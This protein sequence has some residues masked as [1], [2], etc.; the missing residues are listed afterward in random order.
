M[1][2]LDVRVK[3]LFTTREGYWYWFKVLNSNFQTRHQRDPAR[4]NLQK[5]NPGL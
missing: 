3:L 2:M 1:R 4:S 5:L